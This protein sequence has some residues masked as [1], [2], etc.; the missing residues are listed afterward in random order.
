MLRVTNN[1]VTQK[2]ADALAGRVT[3]LSGRQVVGQDIMA[4]AEAIATDPDFQATLE[5]V[6]DDIQDTVARAANPAPG[7]TP[8]R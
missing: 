5:M 8:Y 2:L 4:V 7:D 1:A 6:V 3:E